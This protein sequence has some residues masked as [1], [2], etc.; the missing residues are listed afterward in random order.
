MPIFRIESDF[1]YFAHV[2]KCGGVSVDTYLMER[3]GVI[4]LREPNRFNL[5]PDKRWSRT[6]PVHIP[7]ATLKTMF[8]ADW[9]R[10]SFAVV[11]HPVRRLISAFC[12]ARDHH[13]H[14]P[15]STDFN[16][17]FQGAASWVLDDPFRLGGH[18]APMVSFVPEG[19]RIFRLEDG[20]D[21]IVPYLDDLEGR[22][23][24]PRGISAS[25]VGRWRG[26]EAAPTPT[27]E[28]LAL[29]TRLYAPDFERFGY[30]PID[31]PTALAD[32]PDLPVLSTTGSPPVPPPPSLKGRMIRTLSRKAGL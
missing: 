14:L 23:S 6:S 27:S 29:V 26:G 22:S 20:L 24:G 9:L 15:L 25:N 17:W 2:P 5:P 3:F 30:T 13:G 21:A 18:F 8:P 1:H 7:A 10:S 16:A 28:T 31:D 11:R 4:G 32:L 12:F 19:S